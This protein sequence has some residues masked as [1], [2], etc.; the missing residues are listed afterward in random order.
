MGQ[1]GKILIT[2]EGTFDLTAYRWDDHRF[3]D[4][5]VKENPI[6]T[7]QAMDISRF[8]REQISNME[9]NTITM[10]VIEKI[11]EAKLMEYGLSKASPVRLAKAIFVKRQ[12]VLSENAKRVLER[13]YLRKDSQGRVLETPEAMFRRVAKHIAGAERK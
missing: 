12:L 8:L 9:P 7:S 1:E 2:D 4:L 6:D 10:P 5:L 13:R 11:I 3:S